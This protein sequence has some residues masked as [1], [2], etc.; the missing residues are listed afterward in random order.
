MKL[1][2]F[3]VPLYFMGFLVLMSCGSS[4]KD[5]KAEIEQ[6]EDSLF[7]DVTKMIDKSLAQELINKYIEFADA[8]PNDPETPAT[9]FKAGDMSMNLNMSQQ[10]IQ[11][12]DRIMK[13]YPNYDKTPQCLFLKGY[14]YEND[15]RD[16]QKAKEI[17]E[18]FLV[19][20]PDDDFADDAEISIKNLGK[21]PEDLIRE[22]E[23]KAKQE[24]EI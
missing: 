23:E 16:L 6:M 24:G 7:A 13:E 1:H 18:D 4:D 15:F 20:Y 21:S 11:I 2:R 9:L 10:A 3:F 22:F 12:F 17:Y 14:I 19:K 5:L 8:Y